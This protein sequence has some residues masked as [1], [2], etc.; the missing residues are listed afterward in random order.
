MIEKINTSDASIADTIR[1]NM[2]V[3]TDKENGLLSAANAAALKTWYAVRI[4]LSYPLPV[5]NK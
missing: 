1:S 3:A 2:N 5:L 4:L